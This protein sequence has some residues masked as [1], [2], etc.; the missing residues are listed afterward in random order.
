MVLALSQIPAAQAQ[1][2]AGRALVL[3]DGARELVLPLAELEAMPQHRLVTHTLYD[4]GPQVFEGPL[5]RDIL[6]RAQIDGDMVVAIALNDYIADIPMRD[7]TDWDVIAALRQNGDRLSVR[8]RGPVWIV[9]PRDDD[10]RLRNGN[11]EY[12]WVWQLRE[13]NVE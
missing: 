4:D 2:A 12:R 3:R 11:Y 5:M 10:P 8:D 6:A 1:S 9:Y 13:L 7:F